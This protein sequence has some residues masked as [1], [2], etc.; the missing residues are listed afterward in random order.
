MFISAKKE[1][2]L[3][4]V[5][6][7]KNLP[8][9]L[10]DE[11]HRFQ[12][13]DTIS[14]EIRKDLKAWQLYDDNQDIFCHLEEDWCPDCDHVDLTLNPER[15]TGYNGA[16]AHKVWNAIYNENCFKNDDEHSQQW[17]TIS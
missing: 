16:S 17:A 5:P 6:Y 7:R 4:T 12:I 1:V 14:D 8:S 11:C 10:L 9:G 15:Y 13:D 2:L 3:L